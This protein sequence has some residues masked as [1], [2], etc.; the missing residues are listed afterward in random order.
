[1]VE[2][3]DIDFY[4]IL[5]KYEKEIAL[6][7]TKASG[8]PEYRSDGYK[9]LIDEKGLKREHFE[10]PDFDFTEI[11]ITIKDESS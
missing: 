11:P 2:I 7:P 6:I 10:D 1:M 9:S 5:T 4:A 8:Y 3:M